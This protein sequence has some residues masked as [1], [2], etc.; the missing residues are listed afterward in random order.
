MRFAMSILL[1][2]LQVLTYLRHW[3]RRIDFVP[4]TQVEFFLLGIQIAGIQEILV[5]FFRA[6]AAARIPQRTGLGGAV[7]STQHSTGWRKRPQLQGRTSRFQRPFKNVIV[8]DRTSFEWS[9]VSRDFSLIIFCSVHM[10]GPYALDELCICAG[11]VVQ[12]SRCINL[13]FH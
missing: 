13:V 3:N 5:I 9:V 8:M 7:R 6:R 12:C 4:H 11:S 2:L 10:T 1:L